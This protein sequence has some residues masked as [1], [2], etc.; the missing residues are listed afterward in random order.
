VVFPI[1]QFVLYLVGAGVL[2]VLAALVPAWRASR[3]PVLAAIAT[4]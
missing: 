4:E 3:R 1:G 2:G